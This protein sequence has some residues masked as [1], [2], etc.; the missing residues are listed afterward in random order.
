MTLLRLV[1]KDKDD[2]NLR[3]NAH[4]N[5]LRNR[6]IYRKSVDELVRCTDSGDTRLLADLLFTWVVDETW[7]AK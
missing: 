1:P 6:E 2:D 4:M 5:E 7:R 3:R